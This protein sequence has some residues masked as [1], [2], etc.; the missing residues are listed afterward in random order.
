M[1][2]DERPI[3]ATAQRA[4]PQ[5]TAYTYT[6]A[7][8]AGA[9]L[10]I[11]WVGAPTNYKAPAHAVSYWYGADPRSAPI[12]D[13]TFTAQPL[14]AQGQ[15]LGAPLTSVC[16]RFAW[17]PALSLV[18]TMPLPARLTSGAAVAAWRVS[19]QMAPAVATRPTLGPL[20]LETGAITF[21]PAQALGNPV[22]FAAPRT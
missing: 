9:A 11:R 21:G 8:S 2:A 5:P 6:Q 4:A 16:S 12:A 3:T 15:P 14:G 1:P 10:T 18:I 13:Y 19:A 20:P 7:S 17:S 22:T